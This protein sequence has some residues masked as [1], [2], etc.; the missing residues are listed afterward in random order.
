MWLNVAGLILILIVLCYALIPNL[1]TRVFRVGAVTRGPAEPVVALTF[2]DGPDPNYTPALLDALRAAGVRA[3]FFVIAEKALER[4]HIIERMRREGHDV[5]VHGYR[6]AFVPWLTPWAAIRQVAGAASALKQRFGIV[7]RF[8]RP[9][10]GLCNL[11]SFVPW[12][13]ASHRL[14]TWS[15]MVGDWRVTEP[16]V[17][18]QRILKRL[19]PGAVIVLHDSDETFGAEAGAPAGVIQ[20]IPRLVEEVQARGYA[21]RTVAEWL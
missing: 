14:I 11:A 15:I 13:R 9:T 19:R 18:L 7:T 16:E 20:L 3:T 4:P 6:H 21:F 2:D 12:W 8:Y 17:L 5:Q 1:L 10:W